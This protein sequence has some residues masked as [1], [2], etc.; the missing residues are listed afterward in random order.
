MRTMT[1]PPSHPGEIIKG[2]YLEPLN[3][4]VSAAA[5]A[6]GISRKTLSKIINENG[7]VTP[8]IAMRLSKAFGTT[9]QLWLN[10]QSNYD[11]WHISH[12]SSAWKRVRALLTTKHQLVHA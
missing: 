12:E 2:L 6:L 3:I 10:L 11:I 7:S 8:D 4:T 1:R 9:P 5:D